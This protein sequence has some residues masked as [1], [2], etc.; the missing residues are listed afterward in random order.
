MPQSQPL[1]H[2]QFR[3]AQP[4]LQP[5]MPGW[6]PQGP[7][8]RPPL[9]MAFPQSLSQGVALAAA[10]VQAI[11][12]QP[13]PQSSALPAAYAR[14]IQPAAPQ[15][16][17]SDVKAAGKASVAEEAAEKTAEKRAAAEEQRSIE[18]GEGYFVPPL[19]CV[20][21]GGEN[22]PYTIVSKS[23]LGVGVFSTV[24]AAADKNNKLVALKAARSQAHFQKVTAREVKLLQ[25]IKEIAEK[26]PEGSGQVLT[27]REHFMH[28]DHLMMAFEKLEENLRVAGRQTLDQAVAFA[29]QILFA[30]R[31]LHDQVGLVHC[32]VKPDNLLMRWDGQSIKLTDLGASR[33]PSDLMATDDLQPL[34]YRAPEVLLGAP[35]GRKIDLWSTGCTIY[36]MIVG[37][38]LLRSCTTLREVM[39]SIM[40]LRGAPPESMR[41][42]GRLTRLYFSPLGFHPENGRGEGGDPVEVSS[43]KKKPMQPELAPYVDFGKGKVAL[44]Q[45]QARAQLSRLI[46]STTVIG[47][48]AKKRKVA[49]PSAAEKKLEYLASLIDL[50]MEVDPAE[51]ITATTALC[52][53]VFD[54]VSL[55][56][57]VDLQDA[58]PLPMEAPP[59]LPPTEPPPL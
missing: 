23:P 25:R 1:A 15:Q 12:S 2:V 20:I 42:A 16:S 9:R 31:F 6:A 59:P 5:P 36:E 34:F 44:A 51:R 37:R 58:P 47:A 54:G 29:K 46:G 28:G 10:S 3:G 41:N 49:E 57:W 40:K 21:D 7:S 45:E 27:L 11:P 55:P 32:D 30:L 33:Y 18:K 35:R 8:F 17:A 22:S 38:P 50:L 14:Q 39:E 4:I 24:W 56:P 43:Y 26:D 19:G 53:S 48:A 52:L 13:Q